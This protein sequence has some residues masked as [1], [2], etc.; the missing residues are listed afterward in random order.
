MALLPTQNPTFGQ[1]L[2]SAMMSPL[3]QFG[4]GMLG[5]NI[6]ATPGG[7]FAGALRGGAAG[8]QNLQ[9]MRAQQLQNQIAQQRFEAQQAQEAL[10]QQRAEELQQAGMGMLPAGLSPEQQAYFGAQADPYAAYTATQPVAPEPIKVGG[11]LLDPT[12]YEPL[13]E[14]P[15]QPLVQIQQGAMKPSEKLKAAMDGVD[16]GIFTSVEHGMQF[17]DQSMGQD[18][19][20]QTVAENVQREQ[21]GLPKPETRTRTIPAQERQIRKNLMK[22]DPKTGMT[23][24]DMADTSYRQNTR[25]IDR[26]DNILKNIDKVWTGRIG[27]S[28]LGEFLQS[29]LSDEASAVFN[30]LNAIATLEKVDMISGTG[31]KAFDSEKESQQLMSGLTSKTLRKNVIKTKLNRLRK[32]SEHS[33]SNYD[34]VRNYATEKAG[35]E[36]ITEPLGYKK[37]PEEAEQKIINWADL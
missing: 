28:T 18:T 19:I 34:K 24:M 4:L 17:L 33:L 25:M 9:M 36:W 7:A 31:A 22:S 15:R 23:G 1:R 29:E 8:L 35:V 16:K 26:I 37:A 6:G 12:T 2:E 5:G 21:A 32:I 14:P 13:Y 20:S 11:A 30:D 27:G 3:F 10:E